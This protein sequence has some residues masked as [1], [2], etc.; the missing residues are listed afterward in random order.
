MS[1]YYIDTEYC[2]GYGNILEDKKILM[3]SFRTQ[4]PRAKDI[5]AYVSKNEGTYKKDFIK[6]YNGKC[7]YCG[8][9]IKIIPKTM[10]EID[11]FIPH[12]QT[13]LLIKRLQGIL[14]TS[15]YLVR[16]ATIIRA[17]S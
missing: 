4:H 17:T 11:H 14:A 7:A 13:A 8:T 1:K 12:Q 16:H 9:S 2:P 10:F 6:I 5:H 15:Y 3:D